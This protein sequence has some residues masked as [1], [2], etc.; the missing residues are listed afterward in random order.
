[1]A[2]GC[3]PWQ[4]LRPAWAERPARLAAPAIATET[5]RRSGS[6]ARAWISL[7]SVARNNETMTGGPPDGP[8]PGDQARLMA[9][10]KVAGA[11]SSTSMSK[12]VPG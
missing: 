7:V 10:S 11:L 3:P 12:A 1:M 4:A 2:I 8:R 5:Y 9:M 6:Q